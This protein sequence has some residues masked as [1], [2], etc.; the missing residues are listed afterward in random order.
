MSLGSEWLVCVG[1]GRC[2]ESAFDPMED[3]GQPAFYARRFIASC[4]PALR[5]VLYQEDKVV[6]ERDA[7]LVSART[8][9]REAGWERYYCKS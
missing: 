9:T 6:P 4:C 2:R 8:M 5:A 3:G 1:Q 7:G